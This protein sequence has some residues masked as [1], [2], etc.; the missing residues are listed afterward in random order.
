[1]EH[2]TGTNTAEVGSESSATRRSFGKKALWVAPALTVLLAAS[3]KP[4]KAV[5]VYNA[6]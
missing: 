5:G 6:H 3:V 1:M 2:Q 4:A